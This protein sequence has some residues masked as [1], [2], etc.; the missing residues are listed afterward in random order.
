MVLVYLLMLVGRKLDV[1]DVRVAFVRSVE[2]CHAERDHSHLLIEVRR[3]VRD[4][5][6]TAGREGGER[7]R[8]GSLDACVRSGESQ[9]SL[10]A[11]NGRTTV[12]S[13]AAGVGDGRGG[14]RRNYEARNV[15]GRGEIEIGLLIIEHHG[16]KGI[17]DVLRRGTEVRR[18][19]IAVVEGE[20]VGGVDIASTLA[21]INNVNKLILLRYGKYRSSH[22]KRQRDPRRSHYV[23]T[24]TPSY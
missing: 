21:M 2:D 5:D 16:D 17:V 4:G 23:P 10:V 11:V 22:S 24:T 9:V 3:V 1:R 12:G 18:S 13:G 14:R 6:S 15:V 7:I 20:E 8:E 19:V